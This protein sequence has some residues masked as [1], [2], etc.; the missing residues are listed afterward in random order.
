MRA[1]SA[2]HLSSAQQELVNNLCVCVCVCV[3]VYESVHVSLSAC[4]CVCVWEVCME[5]I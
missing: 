4:A 5:R 3:C 2:G 1:P